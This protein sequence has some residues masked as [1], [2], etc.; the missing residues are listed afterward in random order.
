M[1]R[2]DPG[3]RYQSIAALEEELFG[4]AS[5][6]R[7]AQVDVLNPGSPREIAREYL[8]SRI[9]ESRVAVDP[10]VRNDGAEFVAVTGPGRVGIMIAP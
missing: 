2:Q 5:L 9:L 4:W 1:T 3:R 7:G 10:T 8:T 6:R